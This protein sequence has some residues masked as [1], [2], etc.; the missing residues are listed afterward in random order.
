M[1]CDVLDLL[2]DM[3]KHIGLLLSLKTKDNNPEKVCPG[4][5]KSLTVSQLL[6]N[7]LLLPL[8]GPECSQSQCSPAYGNPILVL[9]TRSG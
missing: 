5:K 7:C 3:E 8:D 9:L 1:L 2:Y 6:L 4:V